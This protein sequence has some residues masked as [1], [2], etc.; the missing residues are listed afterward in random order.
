MYIEITRFG[1][2]MF[3]SWVGTVG[4][5]GWLKFKNMIYWNNRKTLF[6]LPYTP[7]ITFVIVIYYCRPSA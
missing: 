2:N 1:F 5:Y 3:F 4:K 6:I 7:N